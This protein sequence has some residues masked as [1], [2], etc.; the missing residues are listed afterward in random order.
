[1]ASIVGVKNF[2]DRLPL[3]KMD[4][5]YLWALCAQEKVPV[6]HMETRDQLVKKL[7]GNGIDPLRPP[8]LELDPA[9]TGE[10]DAEPAK[11]DYAGFNFF[12]LRNACKERGIKYEMT[13]K[14]TDLLARLA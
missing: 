1:M 3:Y 13:D 4:R 6:T 5:N 7:E 11:I 10:Q 2:D 8:K 14:R 9:I 12:Q